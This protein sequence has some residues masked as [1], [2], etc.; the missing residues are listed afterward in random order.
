MT[1]PVVYMTSTAADAKPAGT[2]ANP[3]VT[4]QSDGNGG[5]ASALPPGPAPAGQSVPTTEA[6][7]AS[8][9]AYS[10]AT[11]VG[12]AVAIICTVAGTATLTLTSGSLVIPVAVGLTIL[13]FACTNAV[14]TTGTMT[15]YKLV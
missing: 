8:A 14:Q 15:L 4:S 9:A 7:Y 1:T 12:R 10:G 6:A 5:T 13:P 3:L 11:T 2:T